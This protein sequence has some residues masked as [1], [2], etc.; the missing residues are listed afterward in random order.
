MLLAAFGLTGCV[1]TAPLPAPQHI[2]LSAENV[3]LVPVADAPRAAV[4]GIDAVANESD[5]LEDL[6]ALPGLRV[7]AVRPQ[8]PA[9]AAGLQIGDVI[10]SINGIE[11]NEPDTLASIAQAATLGDRFTFEVR[12]DT[13]VLEAKLE[14][15]RRMQTKDP[16][17]RYRVDPVMTRAG[18][19][20]ELVQTRDGST[21][22]FTVARITRL[23][24]R[25]PLPASGLQR[26]D[27]IVALDDVPVTSAQ[28]LIN[29][30]A[31][32]DFGDRAV[33]R[34]LPGGAGEYGDAEEVAVRL[35]DPGRRI[36]AISLR[37]L[38]HYENRLDP[39]ATR[40]SLLDFWL[41][42]V[43]AFERRQGEREHRLLSLFRFATGYG[44]LIEETSEAAGP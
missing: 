19:R 39:S 27:A 32:Y 33:F 34:V 30:L 5:S 20:T 7:R 35:W 31:A 26:G 2:N 41:F 8:S 28:H 42:S 13:I 24:P 4:F 1:S 43:Y 23:F 40:F 37:P 9:Q 6:Q 17:E 3:E 18:Y 44:E 16:E 38:F 11:T 22:A 25:S 36:R 15:P 29:R 21:P 12:R 14:A 10:L